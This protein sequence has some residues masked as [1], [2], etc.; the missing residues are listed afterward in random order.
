[1]SLRKVETVE[2]WTLREGVG[3]SSRYVCGFTDTVKE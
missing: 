1:L 2:L 3:L